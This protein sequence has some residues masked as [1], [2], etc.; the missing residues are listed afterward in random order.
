MRKLPIF[1]MAYLLQTTFH[2]EKTQSFQ[3]F[4]FP[5][6]VWSWKLD[7]GYLLA[8]DVISDVIKLIP[9]PCLKTVSNLQITH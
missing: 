2:M 5:E 4:Q 3:F 9:W 7:W 8:H 1:N 6:M